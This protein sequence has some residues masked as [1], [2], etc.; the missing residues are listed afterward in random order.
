LG[1][2]FEFPTIMVTAWFFRS[3]AITLRSRAIAAIADAAK[4][5][6]KESQPVESGK[7]GRRR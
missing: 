7:A 4:I 5:L 1:F 3:R 6:A 2:D